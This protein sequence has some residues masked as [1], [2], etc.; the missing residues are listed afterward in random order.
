MD[1]CFQ[2]FIYK[3]YDYEY[4]ILTCKQKLF[5][6]VLYQVLVR[7]ALFHGYKNERFLVKPGG[8]NILL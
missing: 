7:V 3:F 8:L 5:Q 6:E 1:E 2:L 4:L